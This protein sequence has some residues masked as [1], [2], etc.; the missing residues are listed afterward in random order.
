[1]TLAELNSLEKKAV[2]QQLYTCCGCH[3][4]VD[5]L[6]QGFPFPNEKTMLEK[7][8]DAWYRVCGE[9]EWLEAFLQHPKIG[10]LESLSKKFANTQHLAGSE[11]S[12]VN[13]ASVAVLEALA[14]GNKAYEEKFGFIFI[15][16]AGGK[17]ADEMLRLLQ[18]R[19]KNSRT[20]E[21]HIAMGEQH[22]I[23]IL[24]LKKWLAA[25]DW[26][27]I[28]VSQITTHILD[29]SVGSPAQNITIKLQQQ[30][31]LHWTT[32]CQGVTNADGRISDLLPPQRI[33][34]RGNYRMVFETESYF[35]SQNITAFYPEVA[36][37]F[38]LQT[39]QHYHIPLL[40]NPFGY[41]TYR[42]S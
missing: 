15:V 18:D 17:S 32:I 33:L 28:K 4:W 39:D 9:A 8:E 30:S 7:A 11:Q 20:E 14:A 29:T 1:M 5:I 38:S 35:M 13:Q 10:D 22:K 16:C 24:R 25:A 37:Q 41:S 6:M 2:E 26:S 40:L 21:L 42:G 23:T 31:G 27:Q 34:P 12:G 19:L 36:V 3:R